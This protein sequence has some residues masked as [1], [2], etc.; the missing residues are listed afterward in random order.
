[1]WVSREN[2]PKDISEHLN[3][4]QLLSNDCYRYM[5]SSYCH[6]ISNICT[7]LEY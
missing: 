2:H 3:S 6:Y 7:L 1:M 4:I 5:T